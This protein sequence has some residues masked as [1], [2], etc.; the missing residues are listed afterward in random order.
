[1]VAAFRRFA[2]VVVVVLLAR[3]ATPL[4]AQEPPGFATQVLPI[5]QKHCFE[6]HE[7]ARLDAKG[8][9]RKPKGDLRLDGSAWILRGG[10]GGAVLVAGDPEQSPL[11][12]RV[13]LPDDDPDIMPEKGDRLTA[14]QTEILRR[15]ISAGAGFGAWTGAAAT[16]AEAPPADDAGELPLTGVQRARV[17]LAEGLGEANAGA[18]AKLVE[19]GA[20]VEDLIG[21]GR[22][23]AVS[24]EG[25]RDTVNDATLEALAPLRAHLAELDLARTGVTD[26]ALGALARLPRLV[27]LDLSSTPTST[28]GIRALARAP[29]LR[30]LVLVGTKV[31]AGIA[32]VLTAMPKLAAVHLWRTGCS[33]EDLAALRLARQDLRVIGAP[34]L[35]PPDVPERTPPRRRR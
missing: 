14:E 26:R 20:H 6:C 17:R 31:D 25:H 1:M 10:D 22:L 32:T 15:W 7:A 3:L 33:D 9:L 4:S 13:T 34:D 2:P 5:L 12:Q 35:P 21:D 16:Q 28:A 23:F 30:T 29:E 27:R 11:Y 18:I 8:R 24:F 19:S